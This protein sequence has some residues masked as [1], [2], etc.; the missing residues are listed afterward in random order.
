MK[1]I[2][3]FL[4]LVGIFS[5]NAM[6]IVE[7]PKGVFKG[8]LKP[9]RLLI[10]VGLL[11]SDCRSLVSVAAPHRGVCDIPMKQGVVKPETDESPAMKLERM[12]MKNYFIMSSHVFNQLLKEKIAELKATKSK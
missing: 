11:V 1:K 6:E 7:F 8:V 10:S 3:L 9:E 5:A 12:R 2:M 4:M